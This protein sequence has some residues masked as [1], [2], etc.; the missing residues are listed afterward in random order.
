MILESRTTTG[1]IKPDHVG[2]NV[3]PQRGGVAIH[4]A[5]DHQGISSSTP[6]ATCRIRLRAWQEY[7]MD[8]H[9]WSDLAY[10]WVICQHAIVMVGRGW[11]VRSAANGS[12]DGNDRYLAA[13]WMG[14]TSDPGPSASVLD[15]FGSL[16]QEVRRRGAG[17]DVQPH[18]HFFGTT[19][20]GK[21]LTAMTAAW[22]A[23]KFPAVPAFPLPPGYYFGPRSGPVQSVSGYYSHR[24]DLAVWQAR[25]GLAGDGLYGPLTA[26]AARR[27]QA[28][29]HL[30]TNGLVGPATWSG[31]WK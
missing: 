20:P 1:L 5:G 10:N 17:V 29:H 14:G 4:W 27:V 7:H 9:G 12:N 8:G 16:I 21:S 23:K 6:H 3:W 2:T 22:R 24:A 19:C 15:T 18:Q 13:C 28:S 25:V 30:P 26:A 31:A 11:G